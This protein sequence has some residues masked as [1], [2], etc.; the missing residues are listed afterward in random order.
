MEFERITDKNSKDY[1]E[2]IDVV[3]KSYENYIYFVSYFPEKE[4]RL[5][6]LKSLF[7][8]EFKISLKRSEIWVAKENGV[9]TAVAVLCLPDYKRPNDFVYVNHGFWKTFLTGGVLTVNS[10]VR[11]N[12]K[13]GLPC[14]RRD[15]A[16]YLSLIT[17]HPDYQRRGIGRAFINDF[18]VSRVK[19][20]GGEKLTLF[21]NSEENRL[22]YKK[23]GFSEFFKEHYEYKGRSFDSWSYEKK[24][25]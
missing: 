3:V 14:H 20:L 23:L 10:W 11:M 21:T 6:F 19:S 1:H 15:N 16:W 12:D 24:L 5:R 7:A 9:I 2:A 22:F 18:L 13:A 8:V 25:D 17:I 4:R